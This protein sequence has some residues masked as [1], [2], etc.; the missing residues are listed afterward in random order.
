MKS[1]IVGDKPTVDR[2]AERLT[3]AGSRSEYQRIQCVLIS[4]ED[5]GL[6]RAAHQRWRPAV[7]RAPLHISQ[8]RLAVD[9]I[10]DDVEHA[11]QDGLAK[12]ACSGPPVSSTCIPRARPWVGLSAMSR[13]CRAS[14]WA[15]TS[16]A[17]RPPSPA[18][19]R[20][21]MAGKPPS[22]RMSTT[23]PRTATTTPACGTAVSRF[24]HSGL[25]STDG[26]SAA[27]HL[28][29]CREA[30][31][32]GEPVF[33]LRHGFPRPS[34]D[35]AGVA[36][37]A[38]RVPCVLHVAGDL[39]NDIEHADRHG[40]VRPGALPDLVEGRVHDARKARPRRHQP[41]PPFIVVPQR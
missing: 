40:R 36:L 41:Q 1:L 35:H 31:F 17:T 12:G 14:R 37:E 13:T 20:E 4:L 15:R 11:R 34:E 21:W 22:K 25:G 19:S 26:T 8:R 2:L 10:A 27:Q 9:G 7:H 6:R 18:R 32:D 38:G 30:R 33:C 5:L 39:G 16:M 24:M 29:C 23:L 3:R 28:V